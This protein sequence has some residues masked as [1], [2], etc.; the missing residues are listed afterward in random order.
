[1]IR[2][3]IG[4]S[5]F[6]TRPYTYNEYPVGDKKLTNYTLAEEDY[7]FKVKIYNIHY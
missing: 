7:K 4:G 3:P 5:D 6:S 1:M 2:T